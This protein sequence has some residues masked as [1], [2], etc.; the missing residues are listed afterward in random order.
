MKTHR[1]IT[2][3]FGENG[4]SRVRIP[5]DALLE[6]RR[7]P[8][9]QVDT[10]VYET[11]RYVSPRGIVV[12]RMYSCWQTDGGGCVGTYYVRLTDPIRLAEEFGIESKTVI[13]A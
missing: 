9:N 12:L 8:A 1:I 2:C 13:I 4:K 3:E 10:G 6:T 11:D 5:I 7:T